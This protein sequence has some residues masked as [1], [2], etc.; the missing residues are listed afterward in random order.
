MWEIQIKKMK[1]D[2]INE[3]PFGCV[4]VACW[5]LLIES[6]VDLL[7]K[8]TS[9]AVFLAALMCCLVG[10]NTEGEKMKYSFEW[11]SLMCTKKKKKE[12]KKDKC[13]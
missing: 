10:E 4:S 11:C 7:R 8:S 3:H 6:E 13:T 2:E 9:A 12:K 5:F 1:M